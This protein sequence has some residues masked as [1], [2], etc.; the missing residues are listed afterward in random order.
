[1]VYLVT[2]IRILLEIEW[3]ERESVEDVTSLGDAWF[4]YEQ[5][6]KDNSSINNKDSIY[7][8][9]VVFSTLVDQTSA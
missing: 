1:M 4:F 3:K 2:M 5:E 7:Q 9:Q 8:L 6:T